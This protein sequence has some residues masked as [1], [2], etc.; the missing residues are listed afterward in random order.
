[1]GYR[2]CP[3]SR[4]FHAATELPEV[5]QVPLKHAADHIV[6]LRA[7]KQSSDTRVWKLETALYAS[8]A[9]PAVARA[10]AARK[11]RWN[12]EPPALAGRGF[13]TRTRP[14]LCGK[15]LT[16]DQGFG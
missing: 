16:C 5:E 6:A 12:G 14:G 2:W 3:W 11:R 9:A 13:R 4:R 7:L 15:L 8:R 10:N 1:M